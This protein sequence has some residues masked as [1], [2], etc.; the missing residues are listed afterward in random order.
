[1]AD[2]TEITRPDGRQ[3]PPPPVTTP[4]KSKLVTWVAIAI[5][6]V[7]GG[8]EILN[9]VGVMFPGH[10]WAGKAI[11]AAGF[12]ARVAKPL[13]EKVLGMLNGQE[14]EAS[15]KVAAPKMTPEEAAKKLGRP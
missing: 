15:A 4:A 1:M 14:I 3:L 2:E 12:L 9:Q 10:G 6:V 7:G 8:I 5:V 13:L 11:I